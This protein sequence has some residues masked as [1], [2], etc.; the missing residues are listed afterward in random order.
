MA[1][2]R[3]YATTKQQIQ[4]HELLKQELVSN[5]DGT[6]SYSHELDD[7]LIAQRVGLKRNHVAHVRREMFGELRKVKATPAPPE[8]GMLIELLELLI[9]DSANFTDTP[10]RYEGLLKRLRELE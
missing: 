2:T 3:Q 5:S 4:I 1:K 10:G 7:E 9:E 8:R 6:W